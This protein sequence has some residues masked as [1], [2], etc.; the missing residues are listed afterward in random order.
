MGVRST[1]GILGIV[2]VLGGRC[3]FTTIF[4]LFNQMPA[5]ALETQALSWR[6]AVIALTSSSLL[7]HR[8]GHP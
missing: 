3:F 6:V 4:E 8:H 7:F 5:H 1:L 2:G